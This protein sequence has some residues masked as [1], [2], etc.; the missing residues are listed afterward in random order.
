VPAGEPQTRF[1]SPVLP[2]LPLT[3]FV[4]TLCFLVL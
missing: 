3:W 4:L 2:V 1:L